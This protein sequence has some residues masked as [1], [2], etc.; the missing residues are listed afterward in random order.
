MD[1]AKRHELYLKIRDFALNSSEFNIIIDGDE[2]YIGK[3]G[4]RYYL[5]ICDPCTTPYE[6][7]IEYIATLMDLK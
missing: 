6:E 4:Q 3:A 2:E 5:Q 1:A 7:N